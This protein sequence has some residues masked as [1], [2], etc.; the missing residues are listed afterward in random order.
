M[1]EDRHATSVT[2]AGDEGK[3]AWRHATS[4]TYAGLGA[5][6]ALLLLAALPRLWTPAMLREDWRAAAAYIADYQDSSPGLP[7][8]VVAHID[9]TRTPLNWYLRQRYDRDKLPVYF[10][11][12]GVIDGAAVDANFALAARNV[13]GIDVLPTIGANVYDI[14]KRDTLVITKAGVEALEAR[15]AAAQIPFFLLAG[16][17]TETLAAFVRKEK[18]GA[19]VTDFD[20]LKIKRRWKAKLA[21]VLP[22]AFTEVDTHNVVPAWLASPKLEYGAYT[23]R[24]KIHKLLDEFLTD[25]PALQPQTTAWPRSVQ[26]V[27]WNRVREGLKVDT[28]VGPVDS[29]T[30][31]EAGGAR[32][33]GLFLS[34]KLEAYHERRNDPTLD[35]QSDLS[36][37]LHFGQVSAQKLAWEVR[38]RALDTPSGD[39]FLEELIVRR[40][41]S[42]NFCL[43]NEKYDS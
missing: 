4:V 26:R 20:P 5:I 25:F 42:D 27:D 21:E 19:V 43:Y 32:T 14:L 24:P 8:A 18:I 28:S 39:A 15:L 37:Y 6:A 9:Y 3:G 40:E 7:A 22:V 11:F 30:P 16:E 41:L 12:G 10:P 34:K 38:R 36:P 33:L 23:L 1:G 29:W 17:P 13:E 2:Y 31:G 35:G